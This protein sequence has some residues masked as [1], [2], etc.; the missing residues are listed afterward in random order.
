MSAVFQ[1]FIKYPLSVAEN[2]AFQNGEKE[3]L[4]SSIEKAA[5]KA[6]ADSFI[7]ELP[8]GYKTQMQK[9]WTGGQELS[10]GQWQKI[11]IARC[12]YKAST[13]CIFDEPFSALDAI[14]EEKIVQSIQEQKNQRIQVFIT[15]RYSSLCLSDHIFVMEEGRIIGSGS[16][17]QLFETC[18]S[19]AHL[20]KTQ[21][22]AVKQLESM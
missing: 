8:E 12:F 6:T 5:I 15:H 19:Y 17:T 18:P 11:A 14:S 7:K 1:D 21:I 9:E 22:D 4:D 10:L 16:H 2:I 20:I 13:V 3:D